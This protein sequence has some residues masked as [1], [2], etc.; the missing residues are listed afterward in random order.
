MNIQLPVVLWTVICFLVLMLILKN[1]LFRPVFRVMD[2]RKEKIARAKEK[3]AEIARLTEEH[4][5]RMEILRADA[6]IQKQN[7]IK[8][9]LEIIRAK[10]KAETDRMKAKRL[11]NTD[12]YK[13]AAETEK[14]AVIASFNNSSDEIV[15]AFAD[16]LVSQ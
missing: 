12:E 4:E 5:K 16:R 1:L 9:E 6:E 14:E 15:K 8:S 7:L 3:K 2:E 10:N 13:K 11:I